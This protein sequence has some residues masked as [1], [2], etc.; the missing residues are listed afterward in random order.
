[1]PRQTGPSD[2]ADKTAPKGEIIRLVTRLVRINFMVEA[3]SA[4]ENPHP[5]IIIV[6]SVCPGHPDLRKTPLVLR[7]Q[8]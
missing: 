5:P 4:Q 8:Q 2:Q 7:Q 3:G 1:M 6:E